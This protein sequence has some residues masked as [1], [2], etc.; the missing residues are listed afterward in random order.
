MTVHD[1]NAN[2]PAGSTDTRLRSAT[3][4]LLARYRDAHPDL[5][6]TLIPDLASLIEWALARLDAPATQVHDTHRKA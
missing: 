5:P 1:P 3:A 6:L 4:G 2:N